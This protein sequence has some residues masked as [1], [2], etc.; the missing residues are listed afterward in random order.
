MNVSNS[1]SKHLQNMLTNILVYLFFLQHLIACSSFLDPSVCN[2]DE[3][4]Q[5][6]ICQAGICVGSI[7][8]IQDAMVNSTSDQAPIDL[9]IKDF[10]TQDL[11]NDLMVS[12]TEAGANVDMQWLDM[13]TGPISDVFDCSFD[14]NHLENQNVIFIENNGFSTQTDLSIKG[15][16]IYPTIGNWESKTQL[17][18]NQESIDLSID[19]TGL[20]T[21]SLSLVNEGSY[22]LRL[23]IGD[24]GDVKCA[25]T[26]TLVFDQSPPIL[27]QIFP[28]TAEVWLG[29]QAG[30]AKASIRV[31]YSDLSPISLFINDED[32]SRASGITGSEW[33][34]EVV[35][36]EGDN[37]IRVTAIDLLDQ[38]SEIDLMYHYDPVAPVLDIQQPSEVSI[39]QEQSLLTLQGQVFTQIGSTE[40]ESNARVQIKVR[41]INNTD[42]EQSRI[43]TSDQTISTDELGVF[44]FDVFLLIGL[45]E[46][47]VCAYDRANNQACTLINAT[48]APIN[49]CVN[50]SSHIWSNS[51]NYLLNGNV[52]SSVTSLR[53]E[54]DGYEDIQANLVNFAFSVP[55]TL[56]LENP[57]RTFRFIATT[58]TQEEAIEVF[59]V[60]LDTTPAQIN[61]ISPQDTA[62][63]NDEVL[64]VCARIFDLESDIKQIRFNQ[65]ILTLSEQVGVDESWWENFCFE[66][67][68]NIGQNS[69]IF[70]VENQAG[71]SIQSQ[72]ELTV[73]R[74]APTVTF[75][76]PENSWF[77]VNDRGLI[78]MSGYITNSGCALSNPALQIVALREV[79]GE[80]ER[81]DI[82]RTPSLTP[83][84]SFNYQDQFDE[85]HHQLELT[86]N[87]QAGNTRVQNYH[88]AVDQT[89]PEI[90][91]QAPSS[92]NVV[93]RNSVLNLSFEVIDSGSGVDPDS[94][95]INEEVVIATLIPQS[96]PPRFVV[97]GNVL[98]EQEGSFPIQITVKD[99]VGNEATLHMTYLYDATPPNLVSIF[100]SNEAMHSPEVFVIEATDTLSGVTEVVVN[101]VNATFNGLDWIA[102][103]VTFN[104]A[105][106]ELLIEVIDTAGNR[107]SDL[108]QGTLLSVPATPQAY[109]LREP[110]R[111]LLPTSL[112]NSEGMILAG[113]WIAY[114]HGLLTFIDHGL[115]PNP[116]LPPSEAFE[117]LYFS[118]PIEGAH[119]THTAQP[120]LP[121]VDH[122]LAVAQISMNNVLTLLTLNTLGNQ[123]SPYIHLWQATSEVNDGTAIIGE[124]PFS[125]E[126]WVEV[127]L[128][129]PNFFEASWFQLL[130][131]NRDGAYDIIAKTPN[132]VRALQQTE[133]GLFQELNPNDINNL[134]LDQFNHLKAPLPIDL[135]QDHVTDVLQ[136]T[137]DGQSMTAYISQFSN[138][139]Y[140]YQIATNFPT[141]VGQFWTLIDWDHDGSLDLMA[142]LNQE[143]VHYQW[144][145]ITQTWLQNFTGIQ[146]PVGIKG[147]FT[148]NVDLDAQEELC[149]Y[150]E[151][152]MKFYKSNGEVSF[153]LVP[154]LSSLGII[155]QVIATDLD[156][157]NDQDWYLLSDHGLW[158]LLSNTYQIDPQVVT[159]RLSINRGL[160]QNKDALGAQVYIDRDQDGTF[161]RVSSANPYGDTL[162]PFPEADVE[163]EHFDLKVIFYDRGELGGNEQI[164]T[165]L[166][167][168]SLTYIEDLQ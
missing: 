153:P 8:N 21:T 130:D 155:H 90:N 65:N 62:C 140:Q 18:I 82:V 135:N 25:Q 164:F 86:L 105:Q 116:F 49:P 145:S 151:F 69:L 71:L 14:I 6:G 121:R 103:A 167:L 45:N 126:E 142:V 158:L 54:S 141:Q 98:F 120:R 93:G 5:G 162:I 108:T 36:M 60:S 37:P 156:E 26:L 79:L 92:N 124:L 29:Y 115:N 57:S 91:M 150:G 76:E 24:T 94:I 102:D 104:E 40:N 7:L 106:A 33:N 87:D 129:I 134:G 72:I 119:W 146:I 52:C 111:S 118:L 132:G 136:V 22:N 95:K 125:Q 138:V 157:D 50:V 74:I 77:A 66:Y 160:N 122:T 2:V 123:V 166:T 34:L 96:I 63:I 131:W 11:G 46:V 51:N 64:D 44:L 109:T 59:T 161:E 139:Q 113:R 38:R 75:D 110:E 159:A 47:E 88:F 48:Y 89:P 112:G 165:Q 28:S 107:L 31:Q 144:Q 9:T 149:F 128:G 148:S 4:C 163:N 23:L 41:S 27:N 152:G 42:G 17:L 30:I 73:D 39:I 83:D 58:D 56:N 97:N 147:V 3:D 61:I 154:N 53:I 35:L 143:I 43:L 16:L 84:L 127:S 70:D 19:D 114:G 101:G 100:P 1:I 10:L 133:E 68:P 99:I 80:L 81:D 15:Q 168:N 13:R 137:D 12:G 55:V 32:E 117:V 85:G 67:E 20:F 78:Q